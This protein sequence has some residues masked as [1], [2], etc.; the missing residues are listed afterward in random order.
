MKALFAK[1]FP[2]NLF[3]NLL[4]RMYAFGAEVQA[5]F[6]MFRPTV[7]F[8]HNHKPLFLKKLECYLLNIAAWDAEISGNRARLIECSSK[9]ALLEA[10]FR[11]T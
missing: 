7:D 2:S 5:F 11:R 4:Y 9:A 1:I 10:E 3:L 6:G 8:S